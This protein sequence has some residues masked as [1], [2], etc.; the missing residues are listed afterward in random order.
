MVKEMRGKGMEVHEAIVP[1]CTKPIQVDC[2]EF[3]AVRKPGLPG[4]RLSEVTVATSALV[5]EAELFG[6]LA[7][8]C[9]EAER[10]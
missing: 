9:H 8:F 2:H 3:G 5:E 10:K 6:T 1:V 4:T 7:L